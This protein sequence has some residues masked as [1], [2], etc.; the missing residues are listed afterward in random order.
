MGGIVMSKLQPVVV[1][2]FGATGDLTRRKLL[3]ALYN[4]Y[5]DGQMPER[6]LV[7]GVARRGDQDAFRADMERAIASHS[8]RGAADPA[9]WSKF[10]SCIEYH[11]GGFDEFIFHQLAH[12]GT[13]T[14]VA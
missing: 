12:D 9:E 6:F 4:L 8:R 13:S 5:L 1:V 2:I 14:M 11:V 7:L 10:V 3:P